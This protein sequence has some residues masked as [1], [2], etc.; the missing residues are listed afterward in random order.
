M[1]NEDGGVGNIEV[2]A[3]GTHRVE[4]GYLGLSEIDLVP[5][6]VGYIICDDTDV[7]GILG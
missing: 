5:C 7:S 3:M 4:V 1:R 6:V 2:V